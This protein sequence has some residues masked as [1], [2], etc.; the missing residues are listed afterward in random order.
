MGR[1]FIDI[2]ALSSFS[3]NMIEMVPVAH[4][5]AVLDS[6]HSRGYGLFKALP[7]ELKEKDLVIIE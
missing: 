6:F 1:D 2:I 7:A 3:R 5:K 4:T